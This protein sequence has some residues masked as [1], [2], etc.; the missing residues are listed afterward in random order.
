MGCY[1]IGIDRA[2]A[3]IIEEHHD[4]NGIVWP[5]TAAPYHVALVPVQYDGEM[6][7]TA[8]LLYEKLQNAGLEVLLDDRNERPGVKFKDMDLLGIP[9]QIVVGSKNL[10]K[11]EFKRRDTGETLLL[12]PEEAAEKACETVKNALAELNDCSGIRL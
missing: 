7:N 6:K 1:G 10:P 4:D 8:G 12:S 11:V 9:L 2:L 5:M 3:S